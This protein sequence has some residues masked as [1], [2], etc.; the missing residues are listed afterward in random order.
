MD[1]Q[2]HVAI[3]LDE[4]GTILHS[5]SGRGVVVESMEREY[6]VWRIPA[7]EVWRTV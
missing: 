5:Y 6:Y 4:K 3:C 7:A 2:G 1:D